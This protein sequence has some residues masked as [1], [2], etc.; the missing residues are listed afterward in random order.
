MVS[1]DNILF[2]TTIRENI[3]YGLTE[4]EKV[5]P[6]IEHRIEDACR[7]A[8]IWDDIQTVGTSTCVGVYAWPTATY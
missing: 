2:S 1:Q 8:S 6:D 7:K 5:A 3:I 4:D